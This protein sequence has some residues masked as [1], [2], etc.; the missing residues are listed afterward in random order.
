MR[1]NRGDIGTPLTIDPH[2]ASLRIATKALVEVAR[3]KLKFA[4]DADSGT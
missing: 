4:V 2:G 1:V 3:D